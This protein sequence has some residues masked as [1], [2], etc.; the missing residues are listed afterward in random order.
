EAEEAAEDI[1]T[2][3]LAG[4]A[5]LSDSAGRLIVEDH[6]RR[7]Q[8]VYTVQLLPAL[9]DNEDHPA[10]DAL[11][12]V[13][14]CLAQQTEG[15]IFVQEE[16]FCDADGELLLAEPEDSEEGSGEMP[17]VLRPLEGQRQPE[18]RN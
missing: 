10:W 6:L 18:A 3:H 2:Q 1:L 16:G 11:D 9:L 4:I 8:V 17:P 12:V 15:I 5:T 14:L 7:T 13:L